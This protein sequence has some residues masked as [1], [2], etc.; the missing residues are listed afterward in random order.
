MGIPSIISYGK[1]TEAINTLARELFFGHRGKDILRQLQSVR[2]L[3][4][5]INVISIWNAVYLQKVYDYLVK[6]APK[7]THYMKHI[8]PIN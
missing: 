6:I 4:V 3:N 2:V 1:G 5:L 7:L 8:S